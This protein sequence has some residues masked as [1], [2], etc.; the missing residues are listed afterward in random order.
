MEDHEEEEEQ[1]EEGEF[2]FRAEIINIRSFEKEKNIFDY[3]TDDGLF[4]I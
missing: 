3:F 2:H 4:L 1:G